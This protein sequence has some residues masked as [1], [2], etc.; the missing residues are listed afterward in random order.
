MMQP[1]A[2]LFFCLALVL[3]NGQAQS[4]AE[5]GENILRKVDHIRAAD[6]PMV[7]QVKMTYHRKNNSTDIQQIEIH[8]KNRN[9]SLILYTYPPRMKGQSVLLVDNNLWIY[10]KGTRQP[11]RISARQRML[12]QAS[13]GD[14]AKMT[15]SEDYTATIEGE[16]TFEGHACYKVALTARNRDA[17]YDKATLWVEKSTSHPIKAHLYALSG[18]L[19]K[20]IAYGDYQEKLGAMRP[21]RM[22]I[23]DAIVKGESTI[24]E[25]QD[26]IAQ[27]T[28]E[29]HFRKDYMKQLQ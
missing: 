9:K 19:L 28:P 6:R 13:T 21:M 12:G 15:F 8:S 14:L 16:E 22:V 10:V 25:Y 4:H 27:D 1:R 23:D 29:S 18:K 26:M 3:F 20:T 7:M 17:T 24:L 2:L 5:T 11:I